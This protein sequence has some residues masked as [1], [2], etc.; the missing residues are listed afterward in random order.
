MSVSVYLTLPMKKQ[1]IKHSWKTSVQEDI[2]G[3][4]K[5]T[6]LY[7]WP[8]VSFDIRFGVFSEAQRRFIRAH[9][10]RNTSDIWGIPI[11]H[12]K[13]L[14][15]ATASSGQTILVLD[16]TGNRHFYA[17]RKCILID[18]DNW[19]SYEAG[20]IDTVDS[21]TQITLSANLTYTWPAGSLVF[22]CYECHIRPVQQIN[23]RHRGIN[24]L[25]MEA[26]ESFES[27]RSFSY[28][29]PES[30]ADT[31]NGLDLFVYHPLLPGAEQFKYPFDL[32][33][34]F[35]K[36][37]IHSD[38][39]ETR[40][41][42]RR[43][44]FLSS[45]EEV[46]DMLR[47]FDSKQGRFQVF[48]TPTWSDDIIVTGA[49]SATDTVLTIRPVVYLSSSEIIGRHIYIQFPDKTYICR[50]IVDV[51]TSTT[52]ELDDVIG[53]SVE[54]S[55][56]DEMMVCFLYAAHF[57]AD[58]ILLDHYPGTEAVKVNLTLDTVWE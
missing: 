8:R 9:L 51:P 25:A 12:D 55:D 52:I 39:K 4:E 11:R 33:E 34:F 19:E 17:G 37:Y 28:T 31:Y 15:T 30:G 49:I 44:F 21:S 35:G 45:R 16:D 29:I 47:F 18:P 42:Y 41:S 58:D 1:Q 6:A 27:D 24:W 7:T 22:P 10:Y 57:G 2:E 23:V 46:W 13:S 20:T 5:R 26:T 43:S 48:Y 56:V 50:Q 36:Q 53:T 54:L 3:N 14:L 40:F 38:Y 32:H